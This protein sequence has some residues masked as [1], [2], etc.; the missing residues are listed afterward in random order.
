MAAGF[1]D[2]AKLGACLR[3]VEPVKCLRRDDEVSALIRQR[4]GLSAENK[5]P[6]PASR[7]C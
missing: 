2:A 7:G 3:R 5:L 4:R 1:Q 6:A